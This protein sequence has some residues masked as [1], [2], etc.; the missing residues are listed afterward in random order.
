[1]KKLIIILTLFSLPLFGQEKNRAIH[2][3]FQNV[4]TSYFD[5]DGVHWNE[6]TLPILRSYTVMDLYE[7]D[8]TCNCDIIKGHRNYMKYIRKEGY[9]ISRKYDKNVIGHLSCNSDAYQITMWMFKNDAF[10]FIVSNQ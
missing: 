10:G 4:D 3:L 9:K 1:M 2:I 6:F 7:A 8:T 5:S